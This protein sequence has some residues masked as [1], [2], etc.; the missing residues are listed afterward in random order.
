MKK[1]IRDCTYGEMQRYCN[2]T[3]CRYCPIYIKT[4]SC[5]LL[6]PP[7]TVPEKILDIEIEIPEEKME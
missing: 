5:G 1:K 4:W 6:R 3:C 2:S 7:S